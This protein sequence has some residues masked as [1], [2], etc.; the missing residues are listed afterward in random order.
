M[1]AGLPGAGVGGIFYVLSAL[2]MPFREIA[3]TVSGRSS[4]RRWGAVGRHVGL[5]AAVVTA[6]WSTGWAFG[7][8]LEAALAVLVVVMGGVHVA[9]FLA[10]RR[11]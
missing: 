4:L 7:V 3:L 11:G 5:A 10:S 8:V 9:R 2:W 6:V 1:N